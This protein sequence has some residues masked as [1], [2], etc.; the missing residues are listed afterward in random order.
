MGT[1]LSI[2]IAHIIL[3]FRVLISA[4]LFF[5]DCFKGKLIGTMLSQFST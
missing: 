5:G 4:S 2:K 1:R 3:L